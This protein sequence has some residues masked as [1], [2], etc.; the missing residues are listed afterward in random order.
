MIVVID[1]EEA[2]RASISFLLRSLGHEVRT[3]ASPLH[4]LE[5]PVEP[6]LFLI[7]HLMPGMTGLQFLQEHPDFVERVPILLMT[8]YAAEIRAEA[9]AAG[10]RAILIKPFAPPDLI[11]AIKEHVAP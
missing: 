11:D 2:I 4:Y 10:A 7:D 1:D 5:D 6:D 8:A 3:Y 9:F